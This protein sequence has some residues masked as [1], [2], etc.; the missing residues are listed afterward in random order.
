MDHEI[1]VADHGVHIAGRR[2]EF[3]DVVFAPFETERV[4]N[5]A[6]RCHDFEQR[7]VKQFF[8][9]AVNERVQVPKL[10]DFDQARVIAGNHE[11]GIILQKQ[12]GDVV[13]MHQPVKRG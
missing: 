6:F 3:G 11:I 5:A 1:V 2:A 8:Y 10:I 4:L 7:M 9:P 13:Q 12:I